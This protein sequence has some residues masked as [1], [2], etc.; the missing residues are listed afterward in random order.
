MRSETLAQSLSA[1][2]R[3]QMRAAVL[4]DAPEL[5]SLLPDLTRS[6]AEVRHRT[7]PLL[8]E[9]RQS[10]DLTTAEGLS[11]LDAKHMLLLMYCMHI[12]FYILL[13]LEGQPVKSHP[14]MQRL[15]ACKTYLEKVKGIDKRVKSQVDKLLA[16]AKAA[17][18]SRGQDADGVLS[19]M[20]ESWVPCSLHLCT[21]MSGLRHLEEHGHALQL[22]V[23]MSPC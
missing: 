5:L 14:V 22:A 12:L 9:L 2:A 15:V 11:Y 3:A 4:A 1:P 7:A 20:S 10:P 18:E 13:K 8:T 19:F 6:L 23:G 21:H 16:A 17:H